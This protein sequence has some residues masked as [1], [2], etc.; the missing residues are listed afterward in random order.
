MADD[1]LH[2]SRKSY[3]FELNWYDFET[4]TRKL[5]FELLQPTVLRSAEDREQLFQTRK[6]IESY[7]ARIKELECILLE[8]EQP[9]NRFERLD[10][11][12]VEMETE[13]KIE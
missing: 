7:E 6:S 8:T 1:R 12:L 13:R 9:T 2:I 3:D 5:V 4:R 10:S 11:R